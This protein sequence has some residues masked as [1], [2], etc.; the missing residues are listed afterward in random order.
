MSR[1]VPEVVLL[2]RAAAL[3]EE[4]ASRHR[5]SLGGPLVMPERVDWTQL[6]GSEVTAPL[7]RFLRATARNL[8]FEAGVVGDPGRV[9]WFVDSKYPGVVAFAEAVVVSVGYA[10][11]VEGS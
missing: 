11:E 6:A 1:V 9:R 4:S 8:G 10:M 2:E 7:A 5:A 3:L